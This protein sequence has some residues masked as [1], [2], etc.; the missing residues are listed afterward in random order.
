MQIRFQEFCLAFSMFIDVYLHK[1]GIMDLAYLTPEWSFVMAIGM[2]VYCVL[3]ENSQRKG[4]CQC[5]ED[6]K[7]ESYSLFHIDV[8]YESSF[9]Q[10]NSY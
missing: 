4:V 5:L 8:E 3:S 7:E 9:E 2:M 1:H 10:I 6:E